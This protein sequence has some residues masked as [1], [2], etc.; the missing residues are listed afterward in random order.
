MQRIGILLALLLMLPAL[1]ACASKMISTTP[2]SII[3]AGVT[4]YNIEETTT[5][6]QVHCM[7]YSRDA[8]FIPDD[9]PDGRATFK[10][11]DR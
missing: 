1:S 4:L 2:R 7:Q 9:R 8:E 10:C 6:A 5:K 11:V 3:F